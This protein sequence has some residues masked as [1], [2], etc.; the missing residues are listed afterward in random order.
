MWPNAFSLPSL[1]QIYPGA[2]SSLHQGIQ[3]LCRGGW[4]FPLFI[5]P[6]A[7]SYTVNFFPWHTSQSSLTSVVRMVHRRGEYDF[8]LLD[9]CKQ[10]SCFC[11]CKRN[12]SRAV[13]THHFSSA[14]PWTSVLRCKHSNEGP[15]Y[16]FLYGFCSQY[17]SKCGEPLSVIFCTQTDVLS[18]PPTAETLSAVAQSSGRTWHKPKLSFQLT[19]ENRLTQICVSTL[20][21]HPTDSSPHPQPQAREGLCVISLKGRQDKMF[22]VQPHT[23]NF[24]VIVQQQETPQSQ[25][26]ISK[27]IISDRINTFFF[28]GSEWSKMSISVAYTDWNHKDRHENLRVYNISGSEDLQRVHVDLISWYTGLLVETSLWSQER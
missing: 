3:V 27:H 8:V 13:Q 10:A 21:T 7:D 5:V 4:Y 26:S 14:A 25:Q 2:V 1:F 17:G 12:V 19:A 11:C 6:A 23:T 15:S 18:S 24:T 9:R 28:T 20:L 16:N 22:T